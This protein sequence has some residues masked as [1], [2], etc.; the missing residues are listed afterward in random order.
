MTTIRSDPTIQRN[1]DMLSLPG[2]ESPILCR[3]NH[4]TRAAIDREMGA[5][6]GAT[7]GR[8]HDCNGL[9]AW[10]CR[11]LVRHIDLVPNASTAS[12]ILDDRELAQIALQVAQEASHVLMQGYRSRP[13]VE[14]KGPADL[15]TDWDRR[16]EELIVER[17]SQLTPKIPILAEEGGG[18]NNPALGWYCDP[19]DGTTNYVHGHPFFAVSIGAMR[20]AEPVAGAVV[21]PVLGWTWSGSRNYGSLRNGEPCRVSDTRNLDHAL[22]ATGFPPNR[23]FSPYNNFDACQRAKRRVR[24]VR[25]CGSAAL[26]LCLVADGTYDGYWER[27]LHAWDLVAGTAILTAACGRVTSMDGGPARVHVGHLVASNG[28]LHDALLELVGESP[29]RLPGE[30]T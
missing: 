23:E 30:G 4:R 3:G 25:R 26:D 21:A 10:L 22:L 28:V 19:L 1:P 11:P 18:R 8:H 20:T 24:G 6:P 14:H 5:I 2:K 13:R 15:V 29:L 27:A 17:L 7:G 12:T 9:P 16:S